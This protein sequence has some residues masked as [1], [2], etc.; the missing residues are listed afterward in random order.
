MPKRDPHPL[1]GFYRDGTRDDAGRTHAEIIAWDDERLAGVHDFIQWLFPLPERS[2]ANPTAPVLDLATVTAFRESAEMRDRLR[3]SFDRMLKFYGMKRDAS[4][5]A[6]RILR[7]K[8]FAESVD[9]WLWP[10]NHNHLRLTRILRSV[11]LLGLVSESPA[12]LR[13][14]EKVNRE[15]PGRITEETLEFWREAAS[16][17][18]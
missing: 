5:S 6:P 18:N 1:I 8:N 15:F 2:S 3:A 14:L 17:N 4:G 10:S 9:K 12:L 16:R 13:A 11:R 7:A